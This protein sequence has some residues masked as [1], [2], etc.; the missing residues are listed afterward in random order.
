MY[1]KLLSGLALMLPVAMSAQ[2]PETQAFPPSMATGTLPVMSINTENHEPIIDKEVKINASLD[3]ELPDGYETYSGAAAEHIK[4][5]RLTIKGRGNA[6]WLLDKKPYKLKFESKTAVLGMPKHKHFALIPWPIGYAGWIAS[7]SGMEIARL[8]G[9]PWAPRME[10]VELVLN[11]SYEGLYF[12]VES[13]KID[14]NRLDIYEQEENIT[15]PGLIEGGWLVEIDN[16]EDEFQIIIPETDDINLRVTHKSPE[17]L[18]DV[19]RQ[20]LLDAFTEMNAAI[21]SGD[22]SGAAWAELIDAT[23]VA[24]YF[25]VREL[26]CDTDGYNGSFYLHKDLGEGCKWHFGPMWDLSFQ[27]K[28]DWVMNDHPHYSAVHWIGEMFKT[29]AF[30]FVLAEQWA[31]F[32]PKFERVLESAWRIASMCREADKANYVRWPQYENDS[33]DNKLRYFTTSLTENR[34]WMDAEILR[35]TGVES[36]DA[37]N[38]GLFKVLGNSVQ[39]SFAVENVK[40]N[41]ATADGRIVRAFDVPG[42][43]ALRLSDLPAGLY[44]IDAT[45]PGHAKTVKKVVLQ[46]I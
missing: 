8:T 23:S 6:S 11:G 15:D 16:Y 32:L 25:I 13:M 26:L 24:R 2:S 31:G 19:Q 42:G 29:D 37:T 17:V 20:W 43:S 21:Y 33:T 1:K 4:D 18:S 40:L 7:V 36:A 44:I 14:K 27:P 5:A 45:A 3:V 39:V 10:P 22:T 30:R 38:S 46:F 12:V 28:Q 35:L 34:D 41:V 9:Q